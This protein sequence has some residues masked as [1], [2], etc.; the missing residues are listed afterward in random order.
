MAQNWATFKRARSKQ[1]LLHKYLL[2]HEYFA[3]GQK[4]PRRGAGAKGKTNETLPD[5]IP[6][7]TIYKYGINCEQSLAGHGYRGLS[8]TE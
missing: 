4:R 7:A 2:Q 8:T 3:P 5:L 1:P 6:P